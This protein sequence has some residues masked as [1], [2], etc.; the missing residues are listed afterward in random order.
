MA[1]TVWVVDDDDSVRGVLEA[2]IKELGY[3]VRVFDKAEDAL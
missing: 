3:R 1:T 2:M